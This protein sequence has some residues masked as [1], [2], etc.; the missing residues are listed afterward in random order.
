MDKNTLSNYGWIVIAVLVLSVMI[1]LATPFGEYIKAGVES[2]TAGLFDTS[3]KAMN[4]VMPV[5]NENSIAKGNLIDRNA[6]KAGVLNPNTG[7][8]VQQGSFVSSDFI[9]VEYGKTYKKLAVLSANQAF[10]YDEN[11]EFVGYGKR[12]FENANT[13]QYMTITDE[14]VKYVSFVFYAPDK[15]VAYAYEV[16][17]ENVSQYT[18]SVAF[19]GDSMTAG[20]L[21]DGNGTISATA[22]GFANILGDNMAVNVINYGKS[23]SRF[24]EGITKSLRSIASELPAD[25]YDMI[26]LLGGVNDYHSR[27]TAF[28]SIDDETS[29]TFYGAVNLTFK[30]LTEKYPD[31]PIVVLTPLNSTSTDSDDGGINP[32]TGKTLDD[33]VA[34]IEEVCAQYDNIYIIDTHTWS[35]NNLPCDDATL[36]P[37]KLHPT[38]A[39][40]QK[41]ADYLYNEIVK[42]NI[43]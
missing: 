30:A 19:I 12:L 13:E 10:L 14:K 22:R 43:L 36:M 11:F 35:H 7:E 39:G 28:G 38:V 42:L 26:V 9:P 4:V 41:I 25:T 33:Y 16:S 1:A 18:K 15:D 31:K 32:T 24:T 34:A 23:G 2:T 21:N 37:D 5:K 40:H 17:T 3:E 8:Y 27:G 20:L 29:G 6:M